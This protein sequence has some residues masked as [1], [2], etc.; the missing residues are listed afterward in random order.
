MHVVLHRSPRLSPEQGDYSMSDTASMENDG[1]IDGM[2][3][4]NALLGDSDSSIGSSDRGRPDQDSDI[5]SLPDDF[6]GARPFYILL[7]DSFFGREPLLTSSL[8]K[9]TERPASPAGPR[10]LL[11]LPSELIHTVLE[12]LS[13][14]QLTRVRQVCKALRDHADSDFHWHRHVL[15][16]LP[17]N[18][19]NSP[20][21]FD[22]FRELY[23]CHDP[24]WFIPRNKIWFCDRGLT[25]QMIVVQYDERRGVIEGYH[26]LAMRTRDGFEPWLAHADVHVH[27][28]EPRVQLHRDRPVIQLKP[29]RKLLS[30]DPASRPGPFSAAQPI[31]MEIDSDPRISEVILAKPLSDEVV[32]KHTTEEFPYGYVWPP[33]AVPAIRRV[34]AQA[35]GVL[36][37]SVHRLNMVAQDNWVPSSRDEVSD[38][39]FRVRRWMEM[40]RPPLGVNLGEETVTFSTLDP[41]LYTP[42]KEKPYRGIW[43]G[44]YSGHG[45]E[46][47]LLHQPDS[48]DDETEPLERKEGESDKEFEERFQQERVFRG[49]L[50]AIKLTGDPNVPRGEH[51]FIASDL[52]EAG[53]V[54]VASDAPFEG[55]RVVKSKGHIA[56]MG[57]RNGM[58]FSV[59]VPF[60][61]SDDANIY[62]DKFME[63]QLILMSPNRLAQFWVGFGHISFFERVD[64]DSLLVP[65]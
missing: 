18:P 35:A 45:C 2:D 9:P 19:I 26:L 43:V 29:R 59:L 62:P 50:E 65:R 16:N 24:Y 10:G 61:Q 47:L 28:F 33:P 5:S 23:A 60:S 63:S 34:G 13:P 7:L 30:D 41:A 25:G 38:Q 4:M 40:G 53:F 42:T 64:I 8:E 15:A 22:T 55:A 46:F 44:D 49:R 6:N 51:T 54:G 58:F 14:L 1:S 32:R 11:G 27:H 57:F 17:E 20:Y 31:P 36:P 56:A 52:G 39:A 48:E 37:L 21:P 3:A 12:C